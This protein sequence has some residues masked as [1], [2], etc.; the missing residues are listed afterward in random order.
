LPKTINS[1]I[2]KK[3]ALINDPAQNE[4]PLTTA[5]VVKHQ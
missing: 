3:I 1:I 2:K 5:M 4:K